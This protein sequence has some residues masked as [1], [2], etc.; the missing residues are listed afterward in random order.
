M[1]II[2]DKQNMSGNSCLRYIRLLFII[3]F[4]FIIRHICTNDDV[5]TLNY[6]N[7]QMTWFDFMIGVLQQNSHFNVYY[8]HVQYI[9]VEV[10]V[11]D[12]DT[13]WS[14]HGQLIQLIS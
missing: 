1:Y 5:T 11:M 6:L 12:T 4:C 9:I 3:L 13:V 8:M 14:N 2:Q 10:G 7:Q